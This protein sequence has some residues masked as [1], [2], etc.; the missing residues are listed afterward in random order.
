M[1]ETSPLSNGSKLTG[2]QPEPNQPTS[3]G[4]FQLTRILGESTHSTVWLAFDP[5]LEREVAIKLMKVRASASAQATSPWLQEARR[6]ISLSHANVVA[7][8]EADVHGKQ[9]FLV[10]EYVEGETLATVLR[11]RG[12]LPVTQSISLMIQMLDAL[13]VAHASGIFHGTLTP[14]KVMIDKSGRARVMNFGMASQAIRD[15]STALTGRVIQTPVEVSPDSAQLAAALPLTDVL[16]AGM[17]LTDMLFGNSVFAEPDSAITVQKIL[18]EPLELPKP[19]ATDVN[20]ALRTILIH[21]IH[22]DPEQ[23]VPSAKVL[24]DELTQWSA[25]AAGGPG[26]ACETPAGT[27]DSSPLDL[28]LGRMRLKSDFPALSD[29]IVRVQGMASSDTESVGSVTN[30][31]LKDVALTNKLLRLVNSAHF[32]GGGHISTV[33]RAVSL[34]GFNGIRNMALSLVLLEHMQNKTQANLLKEEFLRALMAGSIASELS[35]GSQ[36]REEAFIGT[37]FQNLGRLLAEFYFAEEAK[38]VRSIMETPGQP[39]SEGS[40]ST[41]V[42]GMSYEALALGVARI[43]GLPNVIENCLRK[44]TGAP[45]LHRP[46]DEMQR[47]RWL[48][49]AANEVADHLLHTPAALLN[50][51]V[52]QVASKYATALGIGVKEMQAATVLARQK[53]I[54]MASSMDIKVPVHS[55]ASRLLEPPPSIPEDTDTK[56]YEADALED[57]ALQAATA[58]DPLQTLL[59]KTVDQ[60]RIA[61]VLAAGIQD[62]TNA[63]VEEFKLTD[64]LRMILETMFR[65]MS[66]QRVVFCMRDPKTDT[67]TGRFG[68]GKGAEALAKK[69]VISL[70]PNPNDLFSAVCLKSDDTMVDDAS[71]PR[72]ASRL[73]AWYLTSVNAQTFLLLPLSIKSKPFGLIYADKAEKGEMVLDAQELALL[74][75]LRNQAIMAFRQSS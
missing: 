69:F 27:T 60:R 13:V 66:F 19:L 10:F 21:A 67:L 24:R 4:R 75:T 46:V 8:F 58:I 31:I 63:M 11:E 42:L 61:E 64:V 73:P 6:V 1:S 12:P 45:P 26:P 49:L 52:T 40:A 36:E 35:L 56:A 25:W 54:D 68:L 16:S 5:L 48:A 72:I 32:G 2:R 74:R 37:M 65:S 41:R 9:P 62:V 59:T 15:D 34:V 17:V 44:P 57:L 39:V 30:E 28:L 7:L 23:R 51:K 20:D 55:A 70:K 71:E 22:H 33:S 50:G 3:L 38:T 53:F 43:W 18:N 47:L 29:S 14:S